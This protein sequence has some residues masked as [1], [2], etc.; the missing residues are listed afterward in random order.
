M[1]KSPFFSGQIAAN[2]NA[3]DLSATVV[4]EALDEALAKL[5][6]IIE[7]QPDQRHY[8]SSYAMTVVKSVGIQLDVYAALTPAPKA[9]ADP[10]PAAPKGSQA[11]A[12]QRVQRLK[13]KGQQVPKALQDAADG[14]A[15]AKPAAKPKTTR[16]AK[17]GGNAITAPARAE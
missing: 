13:S 14:K 8:V 15:P 9:K 17:G 4:R 1:S 16:K 7:A 2:D 11:D 5:Q 6:S 10:K 3:A 12:V